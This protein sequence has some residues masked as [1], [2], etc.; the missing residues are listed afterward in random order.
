MDNKDRIMV[1][2]Q[3]IEGD[4]SEGEEKQGQIRHKK[5]MIWYLC[6]FVLHGAFYL[7]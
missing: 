6:L 2:R 1:I 7:R 5:M 4:E 3:Q